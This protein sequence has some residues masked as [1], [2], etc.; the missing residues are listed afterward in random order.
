MQSGR[1]CQSADPSPAA[2]AGF[3]FGWVVLFTSKAALELF[4]VEAQ[5][6]KNDGASPITFICGPVSLTHLFRNLV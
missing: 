5:K 6:E 4:S 1:R 3:P 2:S